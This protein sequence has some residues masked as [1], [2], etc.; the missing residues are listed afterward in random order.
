MWR[1]I[2][3][4]PEAI[5]VHFSAALTKRR[6][7]IRSP[8]Q[9]QIPQLLQVGPNYLRESARTW[10]STKEGNRRHLSRVRKISS[11]LHTG[12]ETVS[13]KSLP[14]GTRLTHSNFM[15]QF[16]LILTW[17]ASTK[18]I[19][20]TAKGNRTSRKRILYPQMMRC[21]S[22]CWWSQRGHLYWTNSYWKPYDSAMWGMVS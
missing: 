8:L 12:G 3:G 9:V 5:A 15:C 13:D 7:A 22:V 4:F 14:L 16:S 18:M 17:S 21:F 19:L 1:P 2:A 11:N 10:V 20:S 6:V